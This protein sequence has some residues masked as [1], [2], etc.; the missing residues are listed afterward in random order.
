MVGMGWV[1]VVKMR[2][3]LSGRDRVGSQWSGWG[4]VLGQDGV[5]RSGRDGVGLPKQGRDGVG[6]WSGWGGS[7]S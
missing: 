4:W 5:G 3:G 6:L 1:S 7:Q 2:V